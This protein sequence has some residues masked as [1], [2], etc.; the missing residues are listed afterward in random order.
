M[1]NTTNMCLKFIKRSWDRRFSALLPLL[2]PSSPALD[3]SEVTN[4]LFSLF[5]SY[6]IAWQS[7]EEIKGM[8]FLS[9][10]RDFL[11]LCSQKSAV[12]F[13]TV[14]MCQV[15]QLG[16]VNNKGGQALKETSSLCAQLCSELIL[17]LK[18][19]LRPSI[20]HR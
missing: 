3:S 19:F 13:L 8:C 10:C 1:L 4:Y 20:W 11:K 15:G 9:A 16:H 6:H 2:P 18:T 14:K 5:W 12:S 17:F 7:C